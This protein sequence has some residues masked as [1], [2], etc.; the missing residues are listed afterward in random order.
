MEEK[1]SVKY[2]KVYV[3]FEGGIRENLELRIGRKDKEN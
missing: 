1:K 2:K 3:F